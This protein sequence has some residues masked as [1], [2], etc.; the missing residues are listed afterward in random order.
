VVTVVR[1][2]TE[3]RAATDHHS[4]ADTGARAGPAGARGAVQV[5]VTSLNETPRQRSRGCAAERCI[6]GAEHFHEL[7]GADQSRQLA[8]STQTEDPLRDPVQIAIVS[9]GQAA[10][11]CPQTISD[12]TEG[13]HDFV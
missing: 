6:A 7:A 1:D 12:R 3:H 5:T 13:M 9:D 4:A 10:A 8:R 2:D 11:W